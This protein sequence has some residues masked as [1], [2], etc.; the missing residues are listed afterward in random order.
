M[1]KMRKVTAV[2]MA[3][4]LIVGMIPID[5]IGGIT[6]DAAKTSEWSGSA[7]ITENKYGY[8][9]SEVEVNVNIQNNPGI[10]GATLNLQYDPK[11]TL[12]S[13]ENGEAWGKLAFTL[14]AKLG[15]PSTFLW[16]SERGMTQEDGTVLKLKFSISDQAVEGDQ[17]SIN[18]SYVPGD[19]YDENLETVNL[20]IVNGCITVV[21]YIPGDVNGDKVVNGKDVTSV[22]RHIVG[23]YDQTI[24]TA[25]A[26]VNED[27]R[28][29]GKDV[30]L[31]RKYIVGDDI[32]LKPSLKKCEHT[33][34]AVANKQ[35]TCTE[36]G[37]VA[38][39]NCTK[40]GKYFTDAEGQQETTL[41]NTVIEAV[42]HTIVTDPAVPATE[43]RTG[44]TE[45]SH[46]SVCGSVIQKQ[47]EIPKLEKTE[48]SINYHIALNDAYLQGLKIENENPGSYSTEQG[49]TL[50]NL[51]E[52]E[53][54]CFE[55]W[56]DGSGNS[57]K[58]IEE[59][60]KGSTGR[61]DL[62]AHWSLV[63][64]S[65]LF[66]SPS[67]P[68]DEMTYTVNKGATL[69]AL[70]WF[71]YTFVGWTN[72]K[73]EIVKR[74]EP[75]TAKNIG[76]RANWTSNR[77]QTRTKAKLDDPLIIEDRDNKEFCF[78][79]EIGTINNVPLNVVENYG[80][81]DGIS[82]VKTVEISNV[83]S[84]T[85]ATKIANVVSDA[86]TKSSEWTLSKD[87][88][89][90]TSVSEEYA[91]QVDKTTEELESV[92]KSDTGKYMV[93]NSS[94]GSKSYS[95]TSG[96]SSYSNTKTTEYNSKD[97]NSTWNTS[98]TD[99]D[100]TDATV[101]LHINDSKTNESNETVGGNVGFGGEASN[102]T[103]TGTKKNNTTTG[104]SASLN[105]G[106]NGSIS[107]KAGRTIDVN[108][109]ND[110]TF[111]ENHSDTGTTGGG[112][113][114]HT[115][116]DTVSDMGSTS[117]WESSSNSSST[118]N[119]SK[120]YENSSTTSVNK[121]VSNAI[122]EMVSQSYGYGVSQSEG[123]SRSTA[124]STGTTS[125][126]SKE[127]TST[128]EYSKSE[129][130]RKTE[131]V[132][133][134]ASKLGY[135]RMVSAGT[136]HVF[137]VV[138]YD[139]ASSSYYTYTY[140]VLDEQVVPYLDYSKDDSTFSDAQN[141]LIP[142]EIPIDVYQYV[143][144]K[145]LKSDGFEVDIET[146]KITG[147][148]GDAQNVIVPEYISVHGVGVRITGFEADVFQNNK[149]LYALTLPDSVT[150]IPSNAFEGCEKLH[151]IYCGGVNKIGDNAF[152]DCTAL[153]I[154]TLDNTIT[155]L[156]NNAFENAGYIYV[157]AANSNVAEATFVSGAKEIEVDLSAL[158][159]E[160]KN[161]IL[162]IADSTD[163]VKIKGNADIVYQ[164]VNI[165]SDAKIT[166]LE[167]MTFAE[168]TEIPLKISSPE[169]SLDRITVTNAP[170][171][172]GVFSAVDTKLQIC[173]NNN[174]SSQGKD[175]V[176]CKKLSISKADSG[177][178]GYLNVDGNVYTA[179]HILRDDL[180]ICDPFT[181]DRM[182]KITNGE[183]KHITT[184]EFD[185]MLS[186][187]KVIFN[188]NEGTVKEE[189]KNVNYGKV[190][191]N[192]P[193]PVR[194]GYEFNG[195]YT[196]VK[197]GSLIDKNTIV[198]AVSDQVLYAR[199]TPIQYTLTYNA[200]GGS[201][202]TAEKK[203][204]V[205]DEF[206]ELP[207]PT[208]EYYDFLGWYSTADGNSSVQITANTK[209][210]SCANM[211]IYARWKEH[212][213]SGW[214]RDS[215]VPQNA[216]VVN[217]KWTYTLRTEASSGSSSMA[218][219]TLYNTVRTGW[220][221]TQGP[222]YSDP[223]NGSR[224]VWSEQY[225]TGRTHHWLYYRYAN[226]SGSQG[227]DKQTSTYKNYD[228]INLTYQLT[229]AGTMGNNSRG[230]RYYYN[231][232]SYR[233]YWYLREYDDVQYGTRWYYQDPVYTYYFY[234]LENKESTSMPGGNGVS[235]VQG[236]VQYRIK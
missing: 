197:A 35:A 133:L 215:E 62:Y 126:Q 208:R 130:Y 29:N 209:L 182:L 80:N 225:E 211:T 59:I 54:Y 60:P 107:Y 118:W 131:S 179:N 198:S 120:S 83:S 228:E 85:E 11:L 48:Y 79:Y 222:V 17:L 49:L 97:T 50:L 47:E 12:I 173:G 77:Y 113:V 189:S 66:D 44:L 174:F 142:F 227:S 171:F 23:G 169:V 75:G 63:E 38:Y 206:G 151:S 21:N 148:T 111:G 216:S 19:L 64:Y 229:T 147:Y 140:N 214:V 93:S 95:S 109:I 24:N 155:E 108:T 20:Q 157:K 132:S 230:W 103:T 14:P 8:P 117:N 184:Q 121:T 105:V 201:V 154:F 46:C 176:L 70:E 124:N 2:F 143:Q 178:A 226:A 90:V 181:T 37:N 177:A 110:T 205:E 234:K 67:Y 9:E 16:D 26:D 202:S 30:T 33:M 233:T 212:A 145:T 68:V 84:S 153:R 149:N 185:N 183:V 78:I 135:Y 86:T 186:N 192:L 141:G 203:I 81:T 188:A 221:G 193:I 45:G 100:S 138:G 57:A 69:P 18:L 220:G 10:A 71:G 195:W 224:N 163:F 89:K 58:K 87:W 168:N 98:H 25:A 15:N 150:E 114:D 194:A 115:G 31:L 42:G 119:T 34:R 160:F 136:V 164:D 159:D 235:N 43:E 74:I 196:D 13:A 91:K 73:G 231:G 139:V 101:G 6:A 40:C 53:G 219:Y 129:T 175:T 190:Y 94:G 92:A 39:W 217:R 41:E 127:Y 27:D 180:Q 56:Y 7:L 76:L 116:K 88:N 72:E 210:S 122:S 207:V 4:I 82:I 32:Q 161:K 158:S 144:S 191:G 236:W 223:G 200:N 5:W 36:N 3:M 102:S 187:C 218:G 1:K 172:A 165:V 137:A 232:S 170:G 99:S 125:S 112:S 123:G 134:A 162:K 28:I 167:T 104:G 22:R 199:W 156:G 152:K 128:V 51:P 65:I 106:I 166:K 61:K 55:G 204:T 146:G 96:G 213:L 52:P